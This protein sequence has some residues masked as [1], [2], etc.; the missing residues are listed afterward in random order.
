MVSFPEPKRKPTKGDWVTCV[1]KRRYACDDS[2]WRSG[3]IV[4]ID[5]SAGELYFYLHCPSLGGVIVLPRRRI[6]RMFRVPTP[7]GVSI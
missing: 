7:L 6:F 1:L 2:V 5:A 4:R 3:R